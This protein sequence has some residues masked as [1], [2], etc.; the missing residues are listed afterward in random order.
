MNENI[1]NAIPELEQSMPA[2]TFMID[3]FWVPVAWGMGIALVLAGLLLWLV[4]SRRKKT[5][6]PPQSP[7]DIAFRALDELS[8]ELPAMRECSLRLSM[9]LRTFLTGQIQD[10]ALFET[11]EEF[12]RRMDA[13]SGVPTSCRYET[14]YLLER[15]AEMKYA[16]NTEQDPQKAR[17]LIEEARGII[18]NITRAQQAEAETAAAVAK[19]QK[20]S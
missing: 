7:Q 20:M 11:H 2:E 9:V 10:P 6:V 15:L 14:L 18:T 3:T 12:S 5:L 19:V 8:E 1:L 13:L 16:G 17:V 4:L